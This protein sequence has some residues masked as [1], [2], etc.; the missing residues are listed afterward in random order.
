LICF[1]APPSLI[2]RFERLASHAKWRDALNDPYI[3][4][5]I[6]LN[7]LFLQVDGI[8]WGLS[9]GF[10]GMEYVSSRHWWRK[11]SRTVA[12][13]ML[14]PST[15]AALQIP[16]AQPDFVGLHNVAKHIIFLK[17]GSDAVLATVAAMTTHHDR[18]YQATGPNPSSRL[19][20]ETHAA[21]EYQKEL[22][23]S[24]SFR[25]T[26]LDRRMQNIINLVRTV[27]SAAR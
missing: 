19:A 17:E 7:D 16:P 24:V 13:K 21:L 10:R 12:D 1:G 3:L 25:I 8:L 22:F 23:Q 11:P 5:V 20:K 15:K 14:I 18:P 26:S 2:Q 6:V 27:P 9:S 4:F